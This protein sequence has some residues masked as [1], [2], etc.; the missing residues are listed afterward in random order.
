[1]LRRH[2]YQ[3]H[4]ALKKMRL[5]SQLPRRFHDM[6]TTDAKPDPPRTGIEDY[7]HNLPPTSDE[8]SRKTQSK[9]APITPEKEYDDD[10]TVQGQKSGPNDARPTTP[11]DFCTKPED[12]GDTKSTSESKTYKRPRTKTKSKHNKYCKL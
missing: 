3:A 5:L 2:L 9:S 11:T 1:M 10:V 6:L 7:T 8:K 4:R 12:L